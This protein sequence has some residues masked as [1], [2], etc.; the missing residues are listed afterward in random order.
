MQTIGLVGGMSW[1]SSAAYYRDLN[2]GVEHR[3]GGLSSAKPV[4]ASVDFAEVTALAGASAGTTSRDPAR[5]RRPRRR[6]GRR[7]LP[8]AVHDDV[9]P[10]RRPGRRPPSTSR[11][12]TSPT[13]SPTRA[14]PPGWSGRLPRHHVRDVRGRSS[15]TGSPPTAS[16]STSPTSAHHDDLNRVIYD[17]LVHGKVLDHSR[18]RVVEPDRRALGRRRRGGHPRLHRA[19]AAGPP[20]RLRHPGLPVHHPARRGR[21]RPRARL[22]RRRD[23]P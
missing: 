2:P 20:G 17:E 1:E 16:P 4:M 10:G 18:R 5:R 15:P 6:A 12:C 11:C 22:A 21:A 23:S 9:P 3:L 13:W 19:R 7:G 14:R 8:A